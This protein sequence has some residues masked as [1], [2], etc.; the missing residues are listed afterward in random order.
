[1]C[2]A[3]ESTVRKDDQ[4][5]DAMVDI[6]KKVEEQGRELTAEGYRLCLDGN[7]TGICRVKHPAKA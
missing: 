5:H 3:K 2:Q 6:I 1:L 7:G 4:L